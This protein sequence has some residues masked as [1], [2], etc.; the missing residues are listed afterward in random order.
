[1]ASTAAHEL[2]MPDEVVEIVVTISN[3]LQLA[4]F[5]LAKRPVK[6]ATYT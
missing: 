2:Y 4:V 5:R 3:W 1:M 6:G